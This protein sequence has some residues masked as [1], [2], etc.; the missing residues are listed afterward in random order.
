MTTVEIPREEWIDFFNALSRL[1]A[2]EPICVEVLRADIGAQLEFNELPLDGIGADL[3][4]DSPLIF[5]AAGDTP[6][7][8]VQHTISYPLHVRVLRGPAGED[9]ALEIE[10]ADSSTTLVFFDGPHG[11]SVDVVA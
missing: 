1:H 11:W 4:G 9:E 3:K 7:R 5:I 6:D 2:D 8:F 10:A